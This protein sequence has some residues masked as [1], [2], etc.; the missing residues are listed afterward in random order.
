M[1]P[2][3][4]LSV[5][6]LAFLVSGCTSALRVSPTLPSASAVTGS[7]S[8]VGVYIPPGREYDLKPGSGI[9]PGTTYVFSPEETVQEGLAVLTKRHFKNAGLAENAGDKR[10]DYV[11]EYQ[12]E[13]PVVRAGGLDSRAPLRFV[14]RD[15][16]TGRELQPIT[17]TGEGAEQGGRFFRIF[18][19]RLAEKRALERSLEEAYSNLF[20]SVDGN[21][22]RTA[23]SL[24]Q[25]APER[26]YRP[27]RRTR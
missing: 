26:T 12:C 18:F 21:L 13:Q 17:L 11:L 16:D 5:L 4:F 23:A 24:T 14:L 19:G 7:P 15:P 27:G 1:K 9:W 3:V 10:W 2:R 6:A 8:R 20:V 22:A 25:S